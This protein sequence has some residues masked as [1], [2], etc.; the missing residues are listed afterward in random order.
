MGF[1]EMKNFLSCGHHSRYITP[2]SLD[3]PMLNNDK[4]SKIP[5]PAMTLNLIM[6][7]LRKQLILGK[8][9]LRIQTFYEIYANI[10]IK[11][12]PVP[13][14]PKLDLL[15]YPM[16]TGCVCFPPFRH[17]RRLRYLAQSTVLGQFWMALGRTFL[18]GS[19]DWL[20]HLVPNLWLK[21]WSF[22]QNMLSWLTSK[23]DPFCL[24]VRNYSHK[25]YSI[26]RSLF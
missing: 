17:T 8:T 15:S 19:L 13:Y 4:F 21:K 24:F 9:F 23:I 5:F 16:M 26:G 11:S 1:F 10:L 3:Q 18:P 25:V 20:W 7:C 6:L 14:L 12:S 22:S 2:S